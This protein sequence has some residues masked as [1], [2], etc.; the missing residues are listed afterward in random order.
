MCMWCTNG[1]KKASRSEGPGLGA[2]Y[3]P[4]RWEEDAVEGRGQGSGATDAIGRSCVPGRAFRVECVYWS[5]GGIQRECPKAGPSGRIT[6]L[7]N[8]HGA[9]RA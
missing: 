1:A 6:S 9:V 7:Y 4:K 2:V 3:S 8:A 5:H